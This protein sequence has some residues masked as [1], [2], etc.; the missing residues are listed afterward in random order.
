M[1]LYPSIAIFSALAFSDLVRGT[2]WTYTEN[3][4]S[5]STG[6]RADITW[7][8]TNELVRTATINVTENN[9]DFD[10]ESITTWNFHWTKVVGREDLQETSWYVFEWDE[11]H[12]YQYF[13]LNSFDSAYYYSDWHNN[14]AYPENFDKTGDE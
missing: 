10:V 7:Q 1:Q 9:G 5:G 3:S 8:A 12:G 14:G 11:G 13:G 4:Y 6:V 2:T